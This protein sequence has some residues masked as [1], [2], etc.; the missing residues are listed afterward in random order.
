LSRRRLPTPERGPLRGPPRRAHVAGP[1]RAGGFRQRGR[2]P[3]R[4]PRRDGPHL[5]IPGALQATLTPSR[6][7]LLQRR[8]SMEVATLI[9]TALLITA[10]VG[11]FV[12]E[13]FLYDTWPPF[14]RRLGFTDPPDPP[15]EAVVIARNQA[16]SN[17][18]LAVG[19][20]VGL[21][22]DWAN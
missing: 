9:I 2:R 17:L 10:H 8:P 12:A 6:G 11:F 7:R 4:Q 20:T 16:V 13:W 19:L 18:F 21:A 1:P 14:R 5:G 3:H 22:L 15:R